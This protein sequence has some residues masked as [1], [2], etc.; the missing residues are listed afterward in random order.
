MKKILCIGL[1][2]FIP[3]LAIAELIETKVKLHKDSKIHSMFTEPI[4][5]LYLIT[6]DCV[7]F[8]A[9]TNDENKVSFYADELKYELKTHGYKIKD[10]MMVIHNHLQLSRISTRDR[11]FYRWLRDNGFCGIF[12]IYLQGTNVMLKYKYKEK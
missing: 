7:M 12:A 1:I 11:K 2:I 4:E 3:C 6:H 8:R 5:I 10:L 9:T